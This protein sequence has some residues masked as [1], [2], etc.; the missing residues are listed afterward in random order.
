ME[1]KLVAGACVLAL[2]AISGTAASRGT[3]E[4]AHA[5]VL[6]MSVPLP[7]GGERGY[8]SFSS[9][10]GQTR[11]MFAATWSGGTEHQRLAVVLASDPEDRSEKKAAAGRRGGFV[12]S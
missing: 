4:I 12:R 8:T 2:A 6:R 11:W 1:A 3:E 5:V 7:F 9:S 10:F